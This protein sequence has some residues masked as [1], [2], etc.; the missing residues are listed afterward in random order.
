MLI[1]NAHKMLE[2]HTLSNWQ[3]YCKNQI[4]TWYGMFLHEA[5]YLEPVMRD[6]EAMLQSTQ[7]NVTGTVIVTLRPYCYT[8]VGVESSFDLVKT[9]FGDYGEVGKGWT[10]EDAKGFTQLRP[11]QFSQRS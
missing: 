3:Q 10:A 8:L 4:G 2:K 7:R 5:Q 1:I 6:C 11:C 9:D